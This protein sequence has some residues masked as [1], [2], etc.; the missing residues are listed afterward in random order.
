MT[1]PPSNDRRDAIVA[2]VTRVPRI[3]GDRRSVA[4]TFQLPILILAALV[5]CGVPLVTFV[6]RIRRQ[7]LWQED[8]IRSVDRRV[9]IQASLAADGLRSV[10]QIGENAF[11]HCSANVLHLFGVVLPA[12]IMAVADIDASRIFGEPLFGFPGMI[13]RRMKPLDRRKPEMGTAI[14]LD[15]PTIKVWLPSAR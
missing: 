1:S 15:M 8:A 6:E 4:D 13:I 3:D 5:E 9:V 11:Y 14:L 12:T 2:A 10:I 7:S